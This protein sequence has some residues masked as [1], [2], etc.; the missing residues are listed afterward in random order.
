MSIAL[1][2]SSA[3]SLLDKSTISFPVSIA[4]SLMATKLPVSKSTNFVYSN[5]GVSILDIASSSY[6][7]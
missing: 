3:F 2:T 1:H 4:F 5:E 7:Q 6:V